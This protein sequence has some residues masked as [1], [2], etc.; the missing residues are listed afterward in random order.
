MKGKKGST[1]EGGVRVPFFIRWPNHVTAGLK[2]PQIAGA[3]DLLPTLTDLAKVPFAPTKPLDG[4]SLKPLLTA[5]GALP[6]DWP[7]REIISMQAGGKKTQLSVRS[8]GF[9]L[10]AAGALYD[11]AADPSQTRNVADAH[12]EEARRLKAIAAQ[13][14]SELPRNFGAD[15]PL[16][17]PVG[18]AKTTQLPARDGVAHGTIQRSAKAPNCS[19]FTHWTSLSDRI[20]W[21]IEVGEKATYEAQVYYTCKAENVGAEIELS[22]GDSEL[23]PASFKIRKTVTDVHDP[24]GYGPEKD[25]SPREQESDV[26]DFKPLVMG[27]I[28]LPAESGQLVLR[29]LKIPGKEAIEVRYVILKKTGA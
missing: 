11:M 26:K 8:Q 6:A 4:R 3:I 19:Y 20:T 14:A 13:F 29:A 5:Q 28:S 12:S 18:Y 22:F 10:D 25:R 7:E 9:R 21:E 16:P 1:D 24:A 2:I 23:N 17:Y 27:N 15:A